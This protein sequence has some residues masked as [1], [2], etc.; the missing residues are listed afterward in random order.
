MNVQLADFIEKTPAFKK[1]ISQ[2]KP[3]T[4]QLIT[5]I[6]GSARALLLAAL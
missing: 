6:S 3:T 5:G 4:R 1:I 2:L